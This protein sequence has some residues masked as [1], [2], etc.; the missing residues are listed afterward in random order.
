MTYKI[1]LIG[2][3]SVG[4]DVLQLLQPLIDYLNAEVLVLRQRQA[5]T[6]PMAT[7]VTQ[8]A[9]LAGLLARK[10]QLIIEAASQQAVLD[11]LPDCLRSGAM[12]VVS[13]VGAFTEHGFLQQCL[14]LSVEHQARI[15]VPSGAIG[16]LDYVQSIRQAPD[17]QITYESWRPLKTWADRLEA[18]GVD[19]ATVTEPYILFEGNAIEAAQ[20]YPQNLNVA[21]T[22]ALAGA[23]LDQTQVRI[24]VDPSLERNQHRIQVRSQLGCMNT[25]IT[26][27]P[28]PTSPK[29]SW[30]VAQSIASVVMR[31]FEA[32]QLR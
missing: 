15:I 9:D 20:K 8:C 29:A 26:N 2:Y 11:Y 30:V 1:A 25:Q 16:G 13:S 18:I 21:V 24:L 10:P 28:S 22:L 7:G 23:G 14:A 17:L 32:L 27:F 31:E 12:V 3:G 6:A 5:G 19:P 4:R